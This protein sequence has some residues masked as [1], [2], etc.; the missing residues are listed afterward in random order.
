VS[1]T[2][3]QLAPPAVGVVPGLPEFVESTGLASVVVGVSKDPNAKVTVLLVSRTTGRAVLA[4]KVPTTSAAARVVD[5]ERRILEELPRRLPHDLLGSVPRPVRMVDAGGLPALVTTALP[6][7]P[8]SRD[9]LG[10]PSAARDRATGHFA[11]AGRWLERLQTATAGT[12]GPIDLDAGVMSALVARF[13]DD[14]GVGEDV[15]RLEEVHARLREHVVPRTVVHGDLWF[16]NLLLDRRRSL[17]VVDWEAS[18]LRGEPL[19]DVARFVNM[20]AL[21]L[22]ARTRRGR[23]VRGLDGLRA[24]D[25]GAGVAFAV[26]GSGWFPELFRGFVRE[27]LDRLGAPRSLWRD[28]VLAGTAEVAAHTDDPGFARAHLR[29]LRRLR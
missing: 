20:Y 2:A 8:M 24:G 7:A 21:Y 16:G 4:V 18:S 6:G 26:G 15:A 17:G 12:S 1:D 5:A 23:R 14:P 27:A 9:Y 13:E 28:V 19:R 3:L 29:L 11:A 25:W 22:D 10:R